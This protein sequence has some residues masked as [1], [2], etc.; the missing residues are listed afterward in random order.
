LIAVGLTTVLIPAN[1]VLPATQ[2]RS[3]PIGTIV[4]ALAKSGEADT[5]FEGST[6]FDGDHLSTAEGKSS[7]RIRLR[8][9]EVV[10]EQ[11]STIDLYDSRRNGF[12]VS[13]VHRAIVVFANRGGRFEILADRLAIRPAGEL[14]IVVRITRVS[15]TEVRLDS[16]KGSLTISMAGEERTIDPGHSYKVSVFADAPTATAQPA[17]KPRAPGNNRFV[18]TM[19]VLIPIVTAIAVWRALASPCRP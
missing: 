19:M 6:V 16:E 7:M 3:Q 13:L 8:N 9:S 11:N 5:E 15:S 18:V 1:L 14:P 4:Q 12:S 10:L 17:T 2:P